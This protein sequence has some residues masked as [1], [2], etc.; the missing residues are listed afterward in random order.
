MPFMTFRNLQD[1]DLNLLHALWALLET[2][3]VTA[4]GKR[5]GLTQSAM[6][7]RLARLRKHFADPLLVRT[8]QSM[9]L[10]DKATLLLPEIRS[11][12]ASTQRLLQSSPDFDP[13]HAQQT[14]RLAVSDYFQVVF[15]PQ[16]LASFET[17]APNIDLN[18]LPN[19]TSVAGLADGTLD[20]VLD[21]AGAIAGAAI[22][23]TPL[24]S[25]GFRLV[26]RRDH[27]LGQRP[28]PEAYAAASHVL[29]SHRGDRRGIVDTALAKL[30]LSR[31]IAVVLP[32]FLGA[33]EIVRSTDLIVTLPTRLAAT[34]EGI[35][36]LWV[37]PPPLHLKPVRLAF[38]WH[39]ARRDD[40]SHRWLRKRLS[41]IAVAPSMTEG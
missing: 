28:T 35:P 24:H 36:E 27:P 31:R 9:V 41:S 6:S 25:D 39:E 20:G 33:M 13:K 1:F 12:V 38:F 30:G 11:I 17:E 29:V 3:G 5:L 40:P 15:L 18:I 2:R 4:A 26:T 16:L 19:S 34:Y 14:L 23:Q 8:G 21:V 7:H 32:D 10:T 22:I 37:Q